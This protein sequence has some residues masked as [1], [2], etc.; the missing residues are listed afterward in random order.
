MNFAQNK[1]WVALLR[2]HKIS[3]WNNIPKLN[4]PLKPI[5]PTKHGKVTQITS[6][7][8]VLVACLRDWQN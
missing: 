5:L 2:F 3:S 7:G 8:V 1:S 6:N 4:V